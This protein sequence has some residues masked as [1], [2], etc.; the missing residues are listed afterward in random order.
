MMFH[1]K[2]YFYE[3]LQN[4]L[5]HKISLLGVGRAASTIKCHVA[6]SSRSVNSHI[7]SLIWQKKNIQVNALFLDI[8][9]ILVRK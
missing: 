1:G 4:E 7:V 3:V 2:K 8:L 6:N 9:T 5:F